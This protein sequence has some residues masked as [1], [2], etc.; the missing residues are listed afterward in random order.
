VRA[1][2]NGVVTNM[3]LRPGTYLASGKGVMALLDSDTLRVEGYFEETKLARIRAG[4]AANV[5]LM[6]SDHT[7]RGS[8]ESVAAG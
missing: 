7:L 8:V 2:V 5:R 1:S 3:E 4:D 6:G